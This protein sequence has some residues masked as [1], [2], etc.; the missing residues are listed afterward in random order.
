MDMR[1]PSVGSKTFLA[2]V[3]ATIGLASLWLVDA[4]VGGL[5]LNT[6]RLAAGACILSGGLGT[7][8][9]LGVAKTDLP[10]RVPAMWLL[11]AMLFV[12]PYLFAGA[13]DAGF[14]MQGWHTLATNPHLA[15]EPWLAGWRAAVWVHGLAAVPWVALIIAAGLRSVEADLEEDAVL[16]T[17]PWRVLLWVSLRRAA[18]AIVVA[19]L[20]IAVI[21][22]TE[23]SV[24]DL[25]QVRT[26][27]EE[28]Y[29]QAALGAFDLSQSEVAGFRQAND[30]LRAAGLWFGLL[31]SAGAAVAVLI[32]ARRLFADHADASH[33]RTWIWHL[34]RTQRWLAATALWSI[35]LLVIGLPIA[36]LAYKAGVEVTATESGR[37]RSWSSAKVI[38][39]VVGAP[40]EHRGELWQSAKIGGA[41]AT[42]ALMCGAPLAWSMRTARRLPFGR[43]AALALCLTIPGPLLGI[44]VI[45]L[46][47]Q[48]HDSWLAW[49]AP[50]YDSTFAPWLVQTI[51]AL[52]IVTLILWAALASIPQVMLDTAVTDHAGWW[53]R[54]LWIALPQRWPAVVA[55]WLIGLAIAVGELA[56]TV[57]VMPPARHTVVAVRIFQLLHYGVDDR[58]A[59]ICLVMVAAVAALTAIAAALVFARMNRLGLR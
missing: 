23:I 9:A 27:A 56:A 21:T 28:T 48:P 57:L 8:L 7:L 6:A 1:N 16:C 41:A 59:A 45:R 38:E 40:W 31:L 3:V 4:R 20:W 17:S 13:W 32:A 51:R 25:F 12:P 37:V 49:L 24:T 50:L 35:L 34:G 30:P 29:T 53:R 14:G 44:G 11:T 15:H 58:V 42:A 2:A 47:N 18:S 22:S 10:G 26:F 54:L 39:R 55:A 36:N 19:G 52:P 5:W 33:R 46:L 43:L